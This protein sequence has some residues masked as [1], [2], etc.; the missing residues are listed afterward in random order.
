MDTA[1]LVVVYT[2]FYKR[3]QNDF[4][5]LNCFARKISNSFRSE[6][7]KRL[8]LQPKLVQMKAAACHTE[9]I[10]DFVSV[11]RLS[12]CFEIIVEFLRCWILFY[13]GF[14]RNEP[15]E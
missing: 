5:I 6:A 3:N 7:E 10:Q 1:E 14:S 2:F 15:F 11:I 12:S 8:S 4:G 13:K 9:M